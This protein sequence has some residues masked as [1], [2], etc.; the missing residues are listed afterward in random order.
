MAN[1]INHERQ[2]I[3]TKHHNRKLKMKQHKS[4]NKT[5]MNSGA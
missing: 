4:N 2:T 1:D 5:N 3:L